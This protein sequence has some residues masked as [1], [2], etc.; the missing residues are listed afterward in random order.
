MMACI[1]AQT[2]PQFILSSESFLRNG[3]GTHVNSKGKILST[4]TMIGLVV[5]VFASRAEALDLNP[6][7]ARIILGQVI[8]VT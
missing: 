2:G 3:V 6:A 1:R 5:K 8:P 4:S 7:C